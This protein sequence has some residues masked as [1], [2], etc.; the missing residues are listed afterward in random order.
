MPHAA[1]GE[2]F[3]SVVCEQCN[4]RVLLFNDLSDGKSDLRQ[5]RFNI[6]CPECQVEGSYVVEHYHKPTVS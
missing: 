6:V 3:I 4:H 5:S 1:S 2:W